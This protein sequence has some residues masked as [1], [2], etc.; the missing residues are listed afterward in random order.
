LAALLPKAKQ[1]KNA[2]EEHFNDRFF[3]G[4]T[5]VI[6]LPSAA[7]DAT[8]HHEVDPRASYFPFIS[9]RPFKDLSSF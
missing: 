5:T 8:D 2:L 1:K 3:N 6:Q 7:A 9:S 4:A